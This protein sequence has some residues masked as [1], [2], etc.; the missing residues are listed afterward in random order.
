MVQSRMTSELA[1]V[2]FTS[3][4]CN[5]TEIIADGTYSRLPS[6]KLACLISAGMYEYPCVGVMASSQTT[7]CV[8]SSLNCFT[9]RN[10]A[11][12]TSWLQPEQ[13]QREISGEGTGR[14]SNMPC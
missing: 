4:I 2:L 12:I 7:K 3:S 9:D 13:E 11:T 14:L 1:A 6:L 10:I 8:E 5:L